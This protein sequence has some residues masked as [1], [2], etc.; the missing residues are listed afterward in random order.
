MPDPNP[1]SQE[2][3]HHERDAEGD[4]HGDERPVPARQA[5]AHQERGARDE[6]ESGG[7]RHARP[8]RAE[9]HRQRAAQERVAHD[10]QD[11][12]V[13]GRHLAD[14][15][16]LLHRRARVEQTGA[17]GVDRALHLVD[18][19]EQQLSVAAGDRAGAVLPA[20]AGRDQQRVREDEHFA[21][22]QAVDPGDV[23]EHVLHGLDGVPRLHHHAAD[24]LGRR[25]RRRGV[26]GGIRRHGQGSGDRGGARTDGDVA[27]CPL[28]QREHHDHPDGE[29]EDGDESGDHGWG[30]VCRERLILTRRRAGCQGE[31]VVAR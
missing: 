22:G 12:A 5:L 27:L 11:T 23:A 24:R 29:H 6:S 1:A 7:D 2:E 28:A 31:E 9:Q 4:P 13:R 14:A 21:L 8:R 20:P 15:V 17:G 26:G 10:P 18:L 19:R 3:E 25:E 30:P 16:D